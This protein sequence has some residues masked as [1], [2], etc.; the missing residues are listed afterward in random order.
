MPDNIVKPVTASTSETTSVPETKTPTIVVV[1][2][3][4]GT[5]P[6]GN[7]EPIKEEPKIAGDMT[8]PSDPYYTDPTFY[9]VANYFGIQQEEYA[10]AKYKLSEVVDYAIREGKSNKPEHILMQ[11]RKLEDMIQPPGWGEKRY[12][13]VYKYVRLASKNQSI[14]QAMSAF[15]KKGAIDYGN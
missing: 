1:K 7:T 15:E 5:V 13:N 11:L 14:K 8:I 9:E 10:A 3:A 4:P 12:T 2:T 6:Q